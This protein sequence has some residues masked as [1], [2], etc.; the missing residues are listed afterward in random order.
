MKKRLTKDHYRSV[1]LGTVTEASGT[2]LKSG[3]PF[4]QFT[5]QFNADR[6]GGGGRL[7]HVTGSVEYIRD[8]AG[9]ES[10]KIKEEPVVQ[11]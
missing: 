8:T 4:R 5:A 3:L 11:K 9:G 1:N 6:I 7:V 2:M 10:F